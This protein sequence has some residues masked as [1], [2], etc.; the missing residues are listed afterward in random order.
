MALTGLI[1]SIVVALI[2]VNQTWFIRIQARQAGVELC[3]NITDLWRASENSWRIMIGAAMGGGFY[4]P[5]L[6]PE[7]DEKVQRILTSDP[8]GGFTYEQVWLSEH[9]RKALGAI[10]LSAE[11][12]LSGRLNPSDVYAILG[13]ELARRSLPLRNVLFTEN[14]LFTLTDTMRAQRGQRERILAL[15]DLMWVEAARRDDLSPWSLERAAEIKRSGS[16]DIARKRITTQ[17]KAVK[18]GIF[19]RWKLRHM[20]AYAERKDFGKRTPQHLGQ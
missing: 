11:L 16:G 7:E 9:C 15:V 14:S 10:S 1:V 17:C 3:N 2:A 19:T 13:L 18:S 20:L 6:T 8:S 5:T 4:S 12:V